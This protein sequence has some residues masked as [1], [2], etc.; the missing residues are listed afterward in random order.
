MIFRMNHWKMLFS[1]LNKIFKLYC[2]MSV[3]ALPNAKNWTLRK[4]RITADDQI[5]TNYNKPMSI[6]RARD[7][8]ANKITN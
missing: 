8:N 6:S 7:Y 4:E 2:P 1:I 5:I 3:I